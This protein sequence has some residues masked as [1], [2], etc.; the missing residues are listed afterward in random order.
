MSKWKLRGCP[1]CTGDLY[2]EKDYDDNLLSKG[3]TFNFNYIGPAQ[4]Y[5]NVYTHFGK[6]THGGIEF[7]DNNVGFA[8][9][10]ILSNFSSLSLKDDD[11]IKVSDKSPSCAINLK[12]YFLGLDCEP[13]V[14]R[15][16]SPITE[17]PL[18]VM[19][20]ACFPLKAS[21]ESVCS[22]PDDKS[23]LWVT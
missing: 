9:I 16:L 19:F 20:N 15:F 3:I 14:I 23:I 10:L 21:N 2:L 1:R 22:T 12:E 13:P 5:F 6:R 4:S 11:I 7:D 18:Y 17:I 8:L